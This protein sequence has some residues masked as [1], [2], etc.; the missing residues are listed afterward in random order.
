MPRSRLARLLFPLAALCISAASVRAEDAAPADT[1]ALFSP[2]IIYLYSSNA[3]DRSF[4][5][6]ARAG[7]E[8]AEHEFHIKVTEKRMSANDNI[9]DVIKQVADSGATPII[10]VG[11]QNVMPVL[12]LAERYPNTRFTVIDGLVPPLFPNVQSIIFKDHEG[13]FLVGMIAAKTARNGHIGFIGGM[14][15]PLIRNFSVGYQQ[16]ARYVNPSVAIDT[17]MVGDKA[18]AWS[19][20]A[21]AHD[22][23]MKQ[24]DNGAEVIFAAA[25]GSGLGVLKAAD[26]TGHYAIGVDT[27]QNGL[28]PGH[29]LTSL[30][31]RVDIAVYDTLKTSS[32]GKWNPGIKYL[33]I[34]EGALDY[35][36]DENNRG[37]ISETLIDQVATAKERIINGTINVEMYSP[38]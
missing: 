9:T 8:K 7:V 20:P 28:F 5:D 18:D 27:N 36:V 38:R 4:I 37:L 12:N 14:D 2:A 6:A 11:Y 17:D 30:V 29:V 15:V 13:A 19:N 21:R 16:G 33:G 25:G 1:K 34:R 3:S 10:A 35:A 32:E 31:K 22:L 26:E 24:F 23:A